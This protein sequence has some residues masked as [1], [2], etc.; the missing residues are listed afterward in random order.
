MSARDDRG[1]RGHTLASHS[2]QCHTSAPF[3]PPS[4]AA[5]HESCSG[6]FPC[7]AWRGWPIAGEHP[8]TSH[9]A[10]S[11]NLSK[12]HNK[13]MQVCC[14]PRCLGSE[15]QVLLSVIKTYP[16]GRSV[17]V[18]ASKQA[19]PLRRLRGRSETGPGVSGRSSPF[20]RSPFR[21]PHSISCYCI[22]GGAPTD[23]TAG[24]YKRRPLIRSSR[25]LKTGRG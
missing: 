2:H 7:A 23:V 22:P 16:L 17:E 11:L 15:N 6:V 14:Y 8:P 25:S 18:M 24:M 10:T 3:S 13:T 5:G 19:D 4:T 1:F 12:P 21:S 20:R 9:L